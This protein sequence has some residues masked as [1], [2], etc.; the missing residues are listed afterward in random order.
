MRNARHDGRTVT[1][2]RAYTVTIAAAAAALLSPKL[3]RHR[4]PAPWALST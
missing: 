1:H 2:S 4:A 3:L